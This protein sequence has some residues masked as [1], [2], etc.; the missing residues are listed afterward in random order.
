MSGRFASQWKM[1]A[2]IA[3]ATDEWNEVLNRRKDS[4]KQE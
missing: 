1:G 3:A 4:A 2:G